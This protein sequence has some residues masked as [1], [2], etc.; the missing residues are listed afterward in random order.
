MIN[1]LYNELV[2]TY[3]EKGKSRNGMK[4]IG[5]NLWI[6]FNPLTKVYSVQYHATKIIRIMVDG[7][8]F[9]NNGEYYTMSTKKH[10]NTF[11]SLLGVNIRQKAGQWLISKD[12]KDYHYYNELNVKTLGKH[13]LDL[14]IN[15]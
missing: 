4:K 6:D 15:T 3:N 1:I 7:T 12:N 10:L 2:K 9:L 13:P 8:C 5:G 14:R 11:L